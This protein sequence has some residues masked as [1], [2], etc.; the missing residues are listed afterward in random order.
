M[1]NLCGVYVISRV[2]TPLSDLEKVAS[3]G[4]VAS[5]GFYYHHHFQQ[6]FYTQKFEILF[7][8]QKRKKR[9]S[10]DE[11]WGGMR[12]GRCPK[13][14][15]FVRKVQNRKE[16][17]ISSRSHV[18]G[19]DKRLSETCIEFFEAPCSEQNGTGEL[20]RIILIA[21]SKNHLRSCPRSPLLCPQSS[22]NPHIKKKNQNFEYVKS[23][24]KQIVRQSGN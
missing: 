4:A 11:T 7:N 10:L 8:T 16:F 20:M 12:Q 17:N 21:D 6:K 1:S 13:R 24:R 9:M 18:G 15:Y 2:N 14:N 19:T 22:P 23:S 3:F 5:V